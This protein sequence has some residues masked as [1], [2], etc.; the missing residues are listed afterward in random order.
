MRAFVVALGQAGLPETVTECGGGFVTSWAD[1]DDSEVVVP[2]LLNLDLASAVVRYHPDAEVAENLFNACKERAAKAAAGDR[3]DRLD[4]AE[5]Y[6]ALMARR[7]AEGKFSQAIELVDASLSLHLPPTPSVCIEVVRLHAALE[8]AEGVEQVWRDML[9]DNILLEHEVFLAAIQGFG[10][11]KDINSVD[12]W[13]KRAVEHSFDK[14][15]EVQQAMF[16]AWTECGHPERF[17]ELIKLR[18]A[19]SQL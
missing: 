16:H 7:I 17:L 18:K 1:S 10:K 14:H 8:D 6:G 2:R 4:A 15:P 12:I 5:L 19:H 9:Y 3:S 11:R 13:V